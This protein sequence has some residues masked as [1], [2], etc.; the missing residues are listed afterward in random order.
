MVTANSKGHLLWLMQRASA[1]IM[2]VYTL[3]LTIVLLTTP[4]NGFADWKALFGMVWFKW[5]TL[6]FLLSLFL[7]AWIGMN[8]VFNDYIP[9]LKLRRIVQKTMELALC[10]YTLWSVWIVWSN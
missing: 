7:H 4:L 10:T 8:G 2:V 1:A 5:I 3:I 9:S 6:L